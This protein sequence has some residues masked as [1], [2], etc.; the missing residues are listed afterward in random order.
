MGGAD[1]FDRDTKRIHACSVQEDCFRRG[2]L[3]TGISGEAPL[4]IVREAGQR[5]ERVTG[6]GSLQP[7]IVSGEEDKTNLPCRAQHA[8][9]GLV[10]HGAPAVG[11]ASR[12]CSRID[13]LAPR[14]VAIPVP[15][16]TRTGCTILYTALAASAAT[17]WRQ[18]V[19]GRRTTALTEFPG[20]LFSPLSLLCSRLVP[21]LF[22]LAAIYRPSS[23]IVLVPVLPILCG[24]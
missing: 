20:R 12:N 19:A 5:R 22:G 24:S 23:R 17:S 6:C 21:A 14:L 9:P 10:S 4:Q 7:P 2:T 15:G 18:Q 3:L 8:P 1:G 16:S 11:A 13:W